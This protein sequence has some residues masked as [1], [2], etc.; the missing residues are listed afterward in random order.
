MNKNIINKYDNGFNDYM[1]LTRLIRQRN[2]LTEAAYDLTK[3]EVNVLYLA[4]WYVSRTPEIE[5]S[6][7]VN[8][9]IDEYS[10]CL[11]VTRDRAGKDLRNAIET[12]YEKSIVF[13]SDNQTWGWLQSKPTVFG[14]GEYE[15]TLSNRVFNNLLFPVDEKD[16]NFTKLYVSEASALKKA[17]HVKLLELCRMTAYIKGFHLSIEELYQYFNLSDYNRSKFSYAE[18]KIFQPA[19]KAIEK[20][21]VYKIKIIKDKRGKGNTITDV[22]FQ[23]DKVVQQ[24]EVFGNKLDYDPNDNFMND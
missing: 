7:T 6:P 9:S 11:G 17:S 3:Q 19:I 12:L 22:F 23:V 18:R 4:R 16:T 24:I 5:K 20:L 14:G 1:E 13:K 8:I 21:G 10:R 15:I 2:E